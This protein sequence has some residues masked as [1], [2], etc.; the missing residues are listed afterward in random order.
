MSVNIINRPREGNTRKT[1]ERFS[2]RVT[3]GKIAFSGIVQAWV[4]NTNITDCIKNTCLKVPLQE[5]LL[6]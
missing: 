5:I 2:L 1:A 6:S 4:E 3:K